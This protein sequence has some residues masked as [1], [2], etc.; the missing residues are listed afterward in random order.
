LARNAENIDNP[1]QR[2][3]QDASHFVD[4]SINLGLDFLKSTLELGTFIGTLWVVGGSLGFTVSGSLVVIPGFLV[5][6]ALLFSGLGSYLSY[7]IGKMLPFFNKQ[8]IA[9]EA[10]LRK[11]MELLVHDAESIKLE[12]GE[13]YYSKKLVEKMN[14]IREIETKQAKINIYLAGFQSI[15]YRLASV[16]P[17]IIAAPLYFMGFTDMG[18]LMQIS[19][20]FDMVNDSL[21]WFIESYSELSKY[22]TS[23]KRIMELEG[24]FSQQNES[25]INL[26]EADSTEIIIDKLSLATPKDQSLIIKGVNI[27]LKEREHVLV[28]GVSGLGK[29]TI[30]KA[31]AGSWI[32]GSGEIIL[33]KDKKIAC[34]AQRPSI[35]QASLQEI[36]AYP[37]EPHVYTLAQYQQVLEDVKLGNFYAKLNSNDLV[38]GLSPGEQQ[39][40]AFARALLQK[41]DWLFLDESTASLD[42]ETEASMY[43]ILKERLPNTTLV[44][45]AHK[46]NLKSY[47]EKVIKLAGKLDDGEAII[48]QTT[49]P[50]QLIA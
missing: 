9:Q 28:E 42:P 38:K 29:S 46:E 22:Q 15:Y 12:R 1:E 48:E 39:R 32:D 35:P 13:E 18:Q 3:Q 24:F 16:F 47:H 43:K 30:F 8:K 2:I 33:P 27:S 7:L 40:I 25:S 37:L 4:M 14:N 34:L 31:I 49:L 6:S 26:K 20:A 19:F 23:I 50:C 17:F 10:E 5:W 41:P 36:L 21:S 45:I 11:E 44:S